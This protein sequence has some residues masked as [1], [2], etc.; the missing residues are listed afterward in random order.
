[1]TD[2]TLNFLFRKFSCFKSHLWRSYL[3]VKAFTHIHA[4]HELIFLLKNVY[5]QGNFCAY[6]L[7]TLNY[8]LVYFWNAIWTVI[9]AFYTW[10]FWKLFGKYFSTFFPLFFRIFV[11]SVQ[12]VFLVVRTGV[13]VRYLMWYYV[14]TSLKFRLDGEPCRVKSLSLYTVR[15]PYSFFLF[16]VFF[17]VLYVFPCFLCV[18]LTCTC[19]FYNLSPPQVWFSTLLLFSF[20]IY[21]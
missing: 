12:T 5:L 21:T 3:I 11:W 10:V 14:W 17:I 1:L 9:S 2:L 19:P 18:L 7:L 6:W 8:I 13:L 20:S 15:L 4:L 16:L